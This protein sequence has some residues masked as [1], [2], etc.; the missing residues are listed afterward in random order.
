[1]KARFLGLD[2]YRVLAILMITVLHVNYQH[3]GLINNPTLS[4]GACATGLFIE[5]LCF[6][7]V[8]C[9]AMLSGYFMGGM[10]TKYDLDWVIR[11]VRFWFKMV[12]FGVVL[13]LTV[14]LFIPQSR[15]CSFDYISTF[16]PFRGFYWYINAY[17]GLMIF[18]PLVNKSLQACSDRALMVVSSMLFIF[19]SIFPSLGLESKTFGVLGGYSISWLLICYI[20]GY[21]VK[22]FANKVLNIRNIK[23]ILTIILILSVLVPFII[24]FYGLKWMQFYNSPFCVLEA[25]C[26]ML[27]LIQ[28]KIKHSWLIKLI[29][30]ISANSL[31]VYLFQNYPYIWDNYI[32]RINPVVYPPFKMVCYFIFVV[33]IL[34]F[35]GVLLNLIVEKIY[36]HSAKI[37]TY[38]GKIKF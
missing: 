28:V 24:D 27:L 9:F 30:F 15:N 4:T 18:M 3:C 2:L 17:F 35:L 22:R 7:G 8:N 23:I 38:W 6:A 25:L 26:L 1:M 12:L 32:F 20:Y 11:I 37:C 34:E 21:V 16:L 29:A 36:K 13:Y 5:Y 31:G 14:F 10:G 33:V 19:F